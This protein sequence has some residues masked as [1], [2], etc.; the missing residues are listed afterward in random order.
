M[1]SF[2][3]ASAYVHLDKS[4]YDTIM[5]A[6]VWKSY[7][8][9]LLLLP[10]LLWFQNC[11]TI[12]NLQVQSLSF[13]DESSKNASNNQNPTTDQG[14]GGNG[15]G[16]DGKLG[17]E[18]YARY[19]PQFQCEGKAAPFSYILPSADPTQWILVKN[20][21][22]KCGYAT[23][24]INKKDLTDFK[25]NKNILAFKD[26]VYQLSSTSVADSTTSVAGD[27]TSTN[28]TDPNATPYD[29]KPQM[30]LV[31]AF[32]AD[33]QNQMEVH[34]QMNSQGVLQGHWLDLVTG[35]EAWVSGLQ[36]KTVLQTITYQQQDFKLMIDAKQVEKTS[37]DKG[38]FQGT[39][40]W[41]KDQAL[42][43]KAISCR[44]AK[45]FDGVVWPSLSIME[46]ASDIYQ[47]TADK[48]SV[49]MPVQK[50]K[51]IRLNLQTNQTDILGQFPG[52]QIINFIFSDKLQTTLVATKGSIQA[53]STSQSTNVANNTI[54]SQML[55]GNN[56]FALDHKT[57][58]IS[59]L[60][61]QGQ[62]LP[63][64]YGSPT[65]KA[66]AQ[67]VNQEPFAFDE[68]AQRV[69][70]LSQESGLDK[71]SYYLKSNNLQ[72][73][74]YRH[75]S[76]ITSDSYRVRSFFVTPMTPASIIYD[77]GKNLFASG[78]VSMLALTDS[79]GAVSKDLSISYSALTEE[80]NE[81]SK[82]GHW[83]LTAKWVPAK[84]VN[85]SYQVL[86]TNLQTMESKMIYQSPS[87][88]IVSLVGDGQHVRYQDTQNQTSPG[89]ISFSRLDGSRFW[90][91]P[92]SKTHYKISSVMPN[93]IANT[94]SNT[95][96]EAL[97]GWILYQYEDSNGSHFQMANLDHTQGYTI[98]DSIFLT[99]NL[100]GF[101]A[102]ANLSTPKFYYWQQLNTDG[103]YHLFQGDVFGL[104]KAVPGVAFKSA[105]A[106]TQFSL[107]S[108]FIIFKQDRNLD[109]IS[110]LYITYFNGM[111]T[112]QISN[113][114]AEYGSVDRFDVTADGVVFH[115]TNAITHRDYLFFW[116]FF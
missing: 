97:E 106:Q 45:D 54:P 2:K 110:E 96:V 31:E 69:I 105:P 48:K 68:A 78:V 35:Q 14:S 21:K 56:L 75:L 95:A 19:I 3:L 115:S 39:V 104:I 101:I 83:M 59:Q 80:Y 34:V 24:T 40:E 8:R 15:G 4:R 17:P 113:R 74:D 100:F 38:Q 42:Q 10:V 66:F 67:S 72:G 77:Y 73:T 47:V 16:Y 12:N 65:G 49:L 13:L 94:T 36:R 23:E 109:G 114:L 55:S 89:A 44:M 61:K 88:L 37:F 51:L 1:S 46:Q 108:R 91:I 6:G 20:S 26:G 60:N 9:I 50:E 84:T 11:K 64:S 111:G 62:D 18:T 41:I 52:L 76:P 22:E 71:T 5:S 116:K 79:F 93:A 7:I 25:S 92:G 28:A 57:K 87:S 29:F 63:Y 53:T 103:L 30:D 107:D 98:S 33:S 43:S 81:V 32:C 102:D 90:S 70:F 82:D 86:M 99:D 85:A 27:A 58:K 112:F